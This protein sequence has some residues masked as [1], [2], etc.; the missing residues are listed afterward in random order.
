M[1]NRIVFVFTIVAAAS[2]LFLAGCKKWDETGT[3]PIKTVSNRG[4][5]TIAYAISS[6]IKLVSDRGFA[7]KDLNRNGKLDP[8]EDWRLSADERA[9]DL[10]SKMT[11]QQIAG[12][13]LYSAHQAIPAGTGMFASTYR[14][15]KFSESGAKASDLTD[16]QMKFLNEDNLRHILITSVEGPEIAA[17]WNNNV[18]ALCERLGLGIP[19]N[20]SSDPRHRTI[21]DAEYN[22]GSGG[23]ISMWPGSLGMASTFDPDLVRKFG[24]IAAREYRALGIT[25]ALSPQIDLGTEPR[26]NRISGTF[27]ESPQLSTDMA[28]AYVD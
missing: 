8:Y 19:A 26:W 28:R 27:G 14:G 12:L 20:N 17:E 7:F 9:K 22:A 11:I 4:G 10:A 2:G 25:T 6:G 16:N 24:Q 3:G 1:K 18:Q 15:R 23:K 5:Q 13:M 21:A